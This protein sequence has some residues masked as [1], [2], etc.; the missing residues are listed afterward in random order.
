MCVIFFIFF[1]FEMKSRLI[2]DSYNKIMK[3]KMANIENLKESE[4]TGS[5][6]N[7]T[8]KFYKKINYLFIN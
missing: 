7:N 6:N 5:I 3:Y 1:Q 2:E 8:L 4:Q